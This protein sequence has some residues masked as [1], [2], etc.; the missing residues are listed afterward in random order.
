MRRNRDKKDP[1]ESLFP[2]PQGAQAALISTPNL[3]FKDPGTRKLFVNSYPALG[4][5]AQP[6][7]T[8][9]CVLLKGTFGT[10]V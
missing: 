1:K 10:K 5:W 6:E 8:P 4:P 3:P 7:G 9:L 2:T